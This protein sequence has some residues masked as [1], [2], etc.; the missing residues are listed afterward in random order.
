MAS[1]LLRHGS[2]AANQLH[3]G[4][5]VTHLS[6]TRMST[7]PRAA[8][9]ARGGSTLHPSEFSSWLIAAA[10]IGLVGIG[11]IVLIRR[12]RRYWSEAEVDSSFICSV[13]G[14]IPGERTPF[15]PRCHHEV[16]VASVKL[17]A[18]ENMYRHSGALRYYFPQISSENELF[19]CAQ[20]LTSYVSG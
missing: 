8:G 6:T 13:T 1:S 19:K 15:S 4:P 18:M 14:T 16:L 5:V 9:R 7:T 17:D 20:M 2:H 3:T 11:A 12:Q 10:S